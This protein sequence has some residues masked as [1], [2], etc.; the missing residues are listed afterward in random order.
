MPTS[1]LSGQLD[2]LAEKPD[3]GRSRALGG[4]VLLP[5]QAH[6]ASRE[7]RCEWQPAVAPSFR[8]SLRERDSYSAVSLS[9]GESLTHPAQAVLIAALLWPGSEEQ[10]TRGASCGLCST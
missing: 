9:V 2:P 6:L 5:F 4:A 8:M 7:F 3:G 10:R 1:R